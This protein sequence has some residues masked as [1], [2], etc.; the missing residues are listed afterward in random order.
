MMFDIYPTES[1]LLGLALG[2]Y[3]RLDEVGEKPS[4]ESVLYRRV[5]PFV[6]D[7]TQE[8]FLPISAKDVPEDLNWH[9]AGDGLERAS[10]LH[11][12]VYCNRFTTRTAATPPVSRWFERIPERFTNGG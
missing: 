9:L 6:P 10:C 11:D 2:E 5:Y 3:L 8:R 1:V 7:Q 12:K 4:F